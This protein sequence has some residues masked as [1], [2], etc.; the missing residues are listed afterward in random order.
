MKRIFLVLLGSLIISLLHAQIQLVKDIYT[1]ADTGGSYPFLL[2]NVNG[3]LFFVATTPMEGNELWKSDGTEDGTELIK[4]IFPGVGLDSENP[5]ELT[6]VN[7][8]LFFV[9]NDGVHGRELWKS[10]GTEAGTV[11]VKD[12]RI[13]LSDGDPHYM[14]AV[15]DEI[16]FVANDGIHHYELWKSDGTSDG[17]YMVKD[18]DP[19]DATSDTVDPVFLYNSNGK[20]FFNATD[21]IHGRELWKSDGTEEGTFM[22][23][24][25][26]A[27]Q[28]GGAA[29]NMITFNGLLYF[30]SFDQYGHSLWRSDGTESGTFKVKQLSEIYNMV[31]GNE[32][33]FLIATDP[34]L[35]AELWRSD[36]TE[37]G[38]V[39]VRDI[40]DGSAD[41]I[42]LLH[43][44]LAILNNEVFF[45]ATDGTHGLEL[46]K[47]DGTAF[48]TSLV[49]DL[50]TGATASNPQYFIQVGSQVLFYIRPSTGGELWRTDGTEEG[51]SLIKQIS[52]GI[53][54]GF[55]C[56]MNDLLYFCGNDRIHSFELWKSN[57]S[58]SGTS[59]VKDILASDNG[60]S[61][62]DLIQNVNDTLY[63]RAFD[64]T[65]GQEIWKSD[66]TEIGTAL[67]QDIIKGSQSGFPDPNVLYQV[68]NSIY[69]WGYNKD[70]GDELWKTDGTV[71]TIVKD[72]A[73][74]VASSKNYV[75]PDFVNIGTT[76]YF[77]AYDGVHG[78]ELWKSDGTEAGTAM[79]KDIVEGQD[80]SY[81]LNIVPLNGILYF[82]VLNSDEGNLWRSD[83]T[84][85]GTFAL[86][87]IRAE[88]SDNVDGLT[89]ASNQLFF[90]ADDGVHGY[91][92]WKTDGTDDGTVLV[93][94]I[95]NSLSLPPK[96]LTSIGAILCFVTDDGIHGQELWKSDGTEAGTSLVR[97]IWP[98]TQGSFP[99]N[100]INV[101]G[102]LYSTANDGTH[103]VELWKS[104]GSEEG[105][106]LIKDISQAELSTFINHGVNVN[107][108]FYFQAKVG[109]EWNLWKSEGTD[110]STIK[111]TSD[112]DIQ[113]S[114]SPVLLNE[115]LYFGAISNDYGVELFNY[116]TND[117]YASGCKL[118]QK[119]VLN[120]APSSKTL[121]DESFT[122]SASASSGLDVV[123]SSSSEK[124][125]INSNTIS[126]LKAGH[127]DVLFNQQG[128]DIY[129]PAKELHLIFCTDPSKPTISLTND[130][131]NLEVSSNAEMGNQWYR[132]DSLIDNATM[133]SYLADKTGNYKTR[134][135]IEGCSGE[136]SESIALFITGLKDEESV[137]P[138]PNPATN[139]LFLRN[140]EI[141]NFKLVDQ[142]GKEIN[143]D[144]TISNNEFSINVSAVQPGVYV[145]L[146]WRNGEIKSYKFVKTY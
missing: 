9:A 143:V 139:H 125:S 87:D 118:N 123:M 25:L 20:L 144:S 63:F 18:I 10:D 128:N 72:I 88:G 66:G 127:V 23:K 78:Y 93:K 92:L 12:I 67:S 1:G 29:N 64:K 81:I 14:T 98:G 119:I 56:K 95:Q 97:D 19:N 58:L 11:L 69:F 124:I 122:I 134:V 31:A 114:T 129:N 113:I 59:M 126:L 15:G 76:I 57:G 41:G 30:S 121:G 39:L 85:S 71:S 5:T 33:I 2:A 55:N 43:T 116:D 117:D 84:A 94:D 83:G 99:E 102:V 6:N 48:G 109:N 52:Y 50:A 49:K 13:G 101:N 132:N 141:E 115:K 133:K 90:T 21:N 100:L 38:T 120:Q 37:N 73:P 79:V 142:T 34:S 35:G 36:G 137:V 89:A 60:S 61:Y 104:D 17:T 62:P 74:G 46:W 146:L 80:N 136:F 145:L 7:G 140:K 53:L 27:G 77:G 130:G 105:T 91:E 42:P 131:P 54:A 107:G 32:Y 24:D 112:N 26:W 110:C 22:V 82:N 51:T 47:S 75:N 8:I 65:N 28:G 3:T 96:Y 45:S 70:T 86:K 135:T 40:N 103:G 44:D 138:Y 16:Y 4:D 111:L 106:I 68:D 108:V